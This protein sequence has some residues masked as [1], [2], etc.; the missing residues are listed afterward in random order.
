[1]TL[2]HQNPVLGKGIVFGGY[3]P[4]LASNNFQFSYY[5]D[6]FVYDSSPDPAAGTAHPAWRQVMTPGFP[7]YRC[8]GQLTCD[9]DTGKTY[10]FGGYVNA[11]V[12]PSKKSFSRPFGDIWELRIDLPGG[13][14][15]DVDRELDARTSKVGPWVRCFYCE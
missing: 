1:M 5:A 14:F 2:I 8:Q 9:P 4:S 10:L 12:V 13:N 11:L 7:T 15:E 3:N 6:T